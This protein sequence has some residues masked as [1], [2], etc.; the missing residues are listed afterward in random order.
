MGITYRDEAPMDIATLGARISALFETRHEMLV[1][2]PGRFI[3]AP[4]GLLLT[5]IEYLKKTDD[6]HF[7]VVDAGMNDL[8]RP[9][10]YEAW[11]DIRPVQTRN[12][13]A[14]AYDVVGPV[15]ESGDFFGHN[16]S[17]S[18]EADDVLA[19]LDAGAYG[20][21]MS[22]HY[23]AR[24]RACEVLIRNEAPILIR[25]RETYDD[26]WKQENTAIY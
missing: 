2:E 26:L 20:M 14:Q 3:I 13:P 1:L 5:R 17:L 18:V 22:S 7:A 12:I 8:I 21:V 24:P 9:A 6:K 19:I 10:L 23:N 15:C 25:E 4:A 16:R 11:H